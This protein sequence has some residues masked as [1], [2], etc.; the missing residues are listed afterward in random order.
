M[1]NQ[2]FKRLKK[3]LF[4]ISLFLCS[5]L[6]AHLV[7]VY[8]YIDAKELPVEWW[9]VTQ[10]VVWEFPH[11]NPLTQSIDYNKNI[12]DLTY[13]SLMKFDN[14]TKQ[15]VWDLAQCDISNLS[16]IDCYLK[17]DVK[18]SDWSEI[19]VWDVLA[20]YNVL[21]NS[22]INPLMVT[23]LKDLT[24]DVNESSKLISFKKQTPTINELQI[25][26]QKIVAKSVLDG[27]WSRELTWKFNVSE[28]LYSWAYKVQSSNYDE[29]SWVQTL[30][31]TKNTNYNE[32]K[33]V[34]IKWYV[35]KIFWDIT[36][37]LKH[38]DII[39]IFF[40][41]NEQ[42]VDI[43][44]RLEKKYYY[45][46]SY[47]ALFVNTLKIKE[48][49]LRKY[50][51]S[52][53]DQNELI[54][55]TWK[56]YKAVTNPLLSWTWW[57]IKDE[58][59]DI[60][61]EKLLND[62]WYYSVEHLKLIE[63][64]NIDNQIQSA[65]KIE[66]SKLKYIYAPFSD[67]FNFVDNEN[68]ILLS[69]KV[70]EY[71]PS[72][73]YVNGY[74][75]QWY[76]V[77]DKDFFYKLKKDFKNISTWEN[78]YKVEFK[79]WNELK[80]IEEFTIFLNTD[81]NALNQIKAKYAPVWETKVE[82]VEVNKDRLNKILALEPKF[83][84][85]NDLQKFEI[86]LYYIDNK[87]ELLKPVELIKSKLEE[88][89]IWVIA[90]WY[91]LQKL[92]ETILSWKKDYDLMLIWIDLWNNFFNLFPYFH[93]SQSWNNFNFSNFKNPYADI[94][95]E[96]LN[97]ELLSKEEREKQENDLLKYIQEANIIKTIYQT[98]KAVYIDK[99]IKNV[100]IPDWFSSSNEILD[101]LKV[102]YI[103]SDKRIQKQTKNVADFINF[104]KKIYKQWIENQE[105]K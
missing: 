96:K 8:L 38:K 83:Y 81:W 73:I 69:W 76:N 50:I 65:Q 93:S 41:D 1:N 44:P 42:L 40:D 70:W 47:L 88:K 98:K 59:L 15:Y 22:N 66:N 57:E 100:V 95:L 17:N 48:N 6:W 16:K 68:E 55:S 74:K 64:E 90:T 13:R 79:V 43:I 75:L 101:A 9:I 72:E 3:Y 49:D 71:S 89:W 60:N 58:K 37:M 105:I 7:Y 53:V 2:N 30:N 45:P 5:V 94:I 99:N 56:D 34:L 84:Y 104:I 26:S 91:N 36:E 82:N 80:F 103:T 12:L 29:A 52:L 97:Q 18:W 62:R 32:E 67:K 23:L 86:N 54:T 51:L 24:I 35:F 46:N 10:A 20:T 87:K 77:W 85:N 14:T 31:L 78:K 21:K 102:W 33:N 4:I 25:L 27:I 39:N 19:T 28:W 61:L 92:N 63:N 11:L